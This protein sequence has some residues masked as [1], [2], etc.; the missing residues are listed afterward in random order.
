VIL[1]TKNNIGAGDAGGGNETA[2]DGAG[3]ASGGNETAADGAGDAG[4]NGGGG[5]QGRV[6]QLLSFFTIMTV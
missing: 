3:D 5:G 2:T 6:V 4:G 1:L